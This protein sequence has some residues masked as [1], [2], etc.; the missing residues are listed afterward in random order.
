MENNILNYINGELIAPLD[1]NWL[2]NY[3]PHNGEVYGQ[4]PNSNIS[5]VELAVTSAEQA[6]G[7]WSSQPKEYRSNLLLKL[8]VL[9]IANLD[10]LAAAECKD[11]G[12]PLWLTQ[13]VDIPRAAENFKFFANAIL[14]WNNESFNSSHFVNYTTHQPLGIVACISPWNLP[15]YLFSWKIAPALASGNCVIAKPSEVTP[16][17]AF[18]LSGLCIE[19]GFP[20][21][22]LNILHG[23]GNTVGNALVTHPKIKAVSFTGGTKTGAAIAAQIAPTFKK[24]SLEL[25]GKNPNVIFADC[26]FEKMIKTTLRSSFENQGQICLC[27][28]RILVEKSIY[29]KFKNEFVAQTQLLKVGNP[30]DATSKIGAI[31]SKEHFEK[32]LNS[33]ALAKKEGGTILCGGNVVKPLGLENGWYISP[34]IIEGL[35]QNC[36]TNQEEIFGPVVTIQSFETESQALEMANCTNYG[37]AATVWTSDLAKANRVA[38]AIESGIVWVNCWLIRDLRTPFGGMKNSG[39][40]RE[41]GFHALE[42][43]TEQKNICLSIS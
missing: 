35:S 30:T 19:A 5:D 23:L 25:G 6:F 27:G 33:I 10:K 11:N 29:E 43:F 8:A 20:N 17:T 2:N 22:V 37:L 13:R 26:D 3:S 42:F 34:T 12:K 18:L 31:V 1:N 21:G 32:I 38:N 4:L 36:I 28:S 39:I 7:H 15:L 16:M 40:G 9:I 41:G 14:Q 24:M